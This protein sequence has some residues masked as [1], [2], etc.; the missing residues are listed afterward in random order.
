MCSLTTTTSMVCSLTAAGDPACPL[1][2]M[3]TPSLTVVAIHTWLKSS[4]F[5]IYMQHAYST[6]SH[7]HVYTKTYEHHWQTMKKSGE[8][9]VNELFASRVYAESTSHEWRRPFK[10]QDLR[11]CWK[12]W[13]DCSHV[14]AQWQEEWGG[15]EYI[16][17]DSFAIISV[18]WL[19]VLSIWS[20]IVRPP[21]RPTIATTAAVG[22][23]AHWQLSQRQP[24]NIIKNCISINAMG[25]YCLYC[26]TLTIFYAQ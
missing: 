1:L 9:S 22:Y 23:P 2:P 20:L 7:A 25:P 10:R 11:Q 12:D 4:C 18:F 5:F 21:Q 6:H 17:V 8:Q 15:R 19:G 24:Q 13:S 14:C 3:A 26:P 16:R